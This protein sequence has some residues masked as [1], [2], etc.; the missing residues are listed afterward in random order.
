V[1]ARSQDWQISRDIKKLFKCPGQVRSG[2]STPKYRQDILEQETD[3][4][5][6]PSQH[7]GRPQLAGHPI[8]NNEPALFPQPAA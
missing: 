7:F 4:G 6:G 5:F 3:S 8:T 1:E 2:D